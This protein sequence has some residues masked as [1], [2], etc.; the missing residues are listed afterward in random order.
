MIGVPM[1][2][3]LAS[4]GSLVSIVRLELGTPRNA[5]WPLADSGYSGTTDLFTL[6]MDVL[7]P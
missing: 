4:G 5:R 7:A 3:E 6:A 1:R 2:M